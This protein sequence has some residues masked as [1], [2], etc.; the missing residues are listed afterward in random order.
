MFQFHSKQA[1]TM[2][3][4]FSVG[5]NNNSIIKI[6]EPDLGLHSEDSNYTASKAS[7]NM[8]A[9]SG[10]SA[11]SMGMPAICCKDAPWNRKQIYVRYFTKSGK[12]Y[13]RYL[14]VT[15][16]G[17]IRFAQY[18]LINI[19]SINFEKTIQARRISI[20]RNETLLKVFGNTR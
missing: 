3:T 2:V 7:I 12:F 20:Y 8:Y 15:Y 1:I 19:E 10:N 16:I 6:T 9:I 11:H 13:T 18:E 5:T 4:I 14:G 17:E